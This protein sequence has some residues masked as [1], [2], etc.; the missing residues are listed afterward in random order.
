[1]SL[2]DHESDFWTSSADFRLRDRREESLDGLDLAH[3]HTERVR[4]TRDSVI[5]R[6]PFA[7]SLVYAGSSP[8]STSGRELQNLSVEKLERL[9]L[10]A[11]VGR[12]D[13]AEAECRQIGQRD[14]CLPEQ[15]LNLSLDLDQ[16]G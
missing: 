14:G 3:G 10:P 9:W 13:V 15:R 8:R 4:D 5:R 16:S 1:M 2:G 11:Q 12:V 7:G 6:S